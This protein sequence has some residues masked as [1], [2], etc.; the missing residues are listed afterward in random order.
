MRVTLADQSNYTKWFAWHPV[1]IENQLV[2]GEVVWRK[3][4]WIGDE[5]EWVYAF[6]EKL[7]KLDP[8]V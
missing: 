6:P 5:Y 4:R 7:L 8:K 3:I 2:W 1:I